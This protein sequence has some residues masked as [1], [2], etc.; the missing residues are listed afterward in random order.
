M[1]QNHKGLRVTQGEQLGAGGYGVVCIAYNVNDLTQRFALKRVR[2]DENRRVGT[3]L[4]QI[5]TEVKLWRKVNNHRFILKL[6]ETFAVGN[7]FYFISELATKGDLFDYI[8]KNFENRRMDL[9]ACCYF[10]NQIALGVNYVHSQGVAHRDLKLENILMFEDPDSPYEMSAKVTDFGLSSEAFD[11]SS[12]I[13][14]D[15]NMVGT[16]VYL[17]PECIKG[18]FGKPVEEE[19]LDRYEDEE[20][21]SQNAV[22]TKSVWSK[23]FE[24]P[25]LSNAFHMDYWALGVILFEMLTKHVPYNPR[26]AMNAALY[27]MW[28]GK[29]AKIKGMAP[30]TREFVRT[31][32]EYNPSK[33]A[34]IRCILNHEW[35]INNRQEQVTRSTVHPPA[36]PPR[37]VLKYVQPPVAPKE[38]IRLPPVPPRKFEIQAQVK[39]SEQSDV[40]GRAAKRVT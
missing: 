10:F 40:V 16:L 35:M 6:I 3:P 24:F 34:T 5:V 7:A 17:P 15:S 33:R 39:Q 4:E 19:A 11:P 14:L 23:R 12:G 9:Q 18:R 1:K 38:K 36:P 27:N 26:G 30:A 31:M 2:I 8:Y 25:P 20:T 32:L 28:R 37:P 29:F 13:I 22:E 21:P